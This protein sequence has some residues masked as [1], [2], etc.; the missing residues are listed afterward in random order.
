MA[1]IEVEAT[2]VEEAIQD[3][4]TRLGVPRQTVDIKILNEGT[5]GLF[6][7][8]GTKPARV[9]LT[10]NAG[11]ESALG[12][13]ALDYPRAEK[14]AGAITTDLLTRM[15]VPFDGVDVRLVTGRIVVDIRTANTALFIDKNAQTLDALELII[16]LM[17]SREP[18]TR[19]K[20]T[21]DC[22]QYRLRQEDQL[23]RQAADAAA[24]VKATGTPFRFEPMPAIA[25]RMIHLALKDDPEIETASEGDGALRRVV[26]TP[27]S[28][29]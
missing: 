26:I 19:V 25:R 13:D 9:R 28:G 12:G 5:A 17:L 16:N 29:A 4:L 10:T 22:G 24:Q 14:T 6:G 21:V 3:G 2:T 27:K 7:L 23:H 8:M 20:V 11:A 15:G 1:E 18:A